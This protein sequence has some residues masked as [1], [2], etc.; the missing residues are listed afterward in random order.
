MKYSTQIKPISYLKANA[1]EVVRELTESRAPS[2]SRR[3]ARPRWLF[4]MSLLRGNPGDDGAARRCAILATSI[5]TL[6]LAFA[7]VVLVV[8]DDNLLGRYSKSRLGDNLIKII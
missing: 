3:T 6:L 5:R 7:V 4:R 8:G 1:A 2:S